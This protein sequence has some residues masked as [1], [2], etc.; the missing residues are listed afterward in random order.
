M[1]E[2]LAKNKELMEK[3]QVELPEEEPADAPEE[4]PPVPI[5]TGAS[6]ANPWMLGKP[7]NPAQE[8]EVQEE[9]GDVEVPGAVESKEEM[10]E[11]EEEV[12]EEEALLQD[13]AQKR[14]A[15]Q[16]QAGSPE[17]QGEEGATRFPAAVLLC[18]C[19]WVTLLLLPSRCR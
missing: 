8:P 5:P 16:Q 2:Q 12:S 7:S 1:Q 9:S 13:F 6:G 10:S 19:S 3:V 17:E 11:E 14:Q 18:L 4:L 15:R